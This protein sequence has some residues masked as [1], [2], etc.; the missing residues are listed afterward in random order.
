MH[1]LADR[2]YSLITSPPLGNLAAIL[3]QWGPLL[4]GKVPDGREADA[5][6]FMGD[7]HVPRS[8]RWDAELYAAAVIPN[9]I[10]YGDDLLQRSNLP[11]AVLMDAEIVRKL[12]WLV[13]P[14][15]KHMYIDNWW[16]DLGNALGTLR[17]VDHVVI[18]HMHP[19]AGKAEKDEGYRRTNTDRMYTEDEAAYRAFID[20]GGLTEAVE[21]LRD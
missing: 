17:Y 2:G 3:N 9:G 13:P 6:G 11:T 16:R 20:R 19:V 7:D 4:A 5:F 12:G 21:M 8:P 18:E 1:K 14:G 15:I 10:A